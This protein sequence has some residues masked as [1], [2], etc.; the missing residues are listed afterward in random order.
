MYPMWYVMF[1]LQPRN[2]LSKDYFKCNQI[3]KV[4]CVTTCLTMTCLPVSAQHEAWR[5]QAESTSKCIEA[6][7]GTTSIVVSTLVDVL[8]GVFV[9]SQASTDDPLTAACVAAWQVVA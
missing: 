3:I 8:T 9:G 5:T 4:N 2:M 1:H 6:S 7:M